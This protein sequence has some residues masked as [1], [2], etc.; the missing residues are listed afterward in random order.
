MPRLIDAARC[1]QSARREVTG[2]EVAAGHKCLT[3]RSNVPAVSQITPDA[4]YAPEAD[5][6]GCWQP[7]IVIQPAR[8]RRRNK[9]A[10]GSVDLPGLVSTSLDDF[11]GANDVSVLVTGATEIWNAD[12]SMGGELALSLSAGDDHQVLRLHRARLMWQ[13]RELGCSRC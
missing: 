13:E 10:H 5:V 11:G 8:C 9:G 4:L 3:M 12:G 6:S 2:L 7:R 1:R